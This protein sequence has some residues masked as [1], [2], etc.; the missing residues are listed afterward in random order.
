MTDHL[1]LPET[2]AADADAHA[3]QTDV[4]GAHGT[5]SGSS[6]EAIRLAAC[7][8]SAPW[9]CLAQ[10]GGIRRPQVPSRQVTAQNRMRTLRVWRRGQTRRR[11]QTRF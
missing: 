5:S 1:T 11:W 7:G 2:A 9:F 8:P 4:A 3:A 6:T 10:V